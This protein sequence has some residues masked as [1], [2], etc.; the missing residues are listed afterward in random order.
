MILFRITFKEFIV[1]LCAC[2]FTRLFFFFLS[3]SRSHSFIWYFVLHIS[4]SILSTHY[5]HIINF[6]VSKIVYTPINLTSFSNYICLSVLHKILIVSYLISVV[7][8][9]LG[10][11]LVFDIEMSLH[12]SPELMWEFATWNK[13]STAKTSLLKSFK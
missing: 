5:V 1:W 11:L 7:F 6:Q 10:M 2:E 12:C 4:V 8:F 13:Y 3:R 9:F